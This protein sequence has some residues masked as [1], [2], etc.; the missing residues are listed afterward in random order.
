MRVQLKKR[1]LKNK[2]TLLERVVGRN[3]SL[4]IL[5]FIVLEAKDAKLI[6]KATNLDV[7][8]EMSIPVKIEKQGSVAVPG[9]LIGGYLNSV[10]DDDLVTLDVVGNNLSVSTKKYS[11]IIKT[12]TT[13][14]FPLIPKTTSKEKHTIP[15]YVFVEGLKSVVFAASTSDIKPEIASVCVYPQKN[16][17]IFVATDSFR[18]AEKTIKTNKEY[19][20]TPILIPLKNTTEII[21]FFEGVDGDIVLFFEKNQLML[22][23]N[24]I[25]FVTRLTD[26][27]YPNYKQIIPLKFKTNTTVQ[28]NEI[29]EALKI[30]NVFLDDFN[31]ITIRI[32]VDDSIME[33]ESKKQDYGENTSRIEAHTN[34]DV[35]EM[36]FNHRYFSEGLQTIPEEK[37]SLKFNEHHKPMV[38]SGATDPT[39]IYLVMPVTR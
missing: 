5:S 9:K 26:G 23:S 13:D 15:S 17:I 29:S 16:S 22:V 27:T 31:R 35:V 20:F 32:L 3:L 14:D 39:F 8:V 34:G 37:I 7:G 2:I 24:D 4:P 33:I 10:G 36:G 28:K 21:K 38:I 6:L 12:N 18:L 11:A 1:D 25:Y 30:S 19:S